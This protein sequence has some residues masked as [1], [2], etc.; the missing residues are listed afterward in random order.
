MNYLNPIGIIPE[1]LT[2][3]ECDLIIGT[4]ERL[5]WD[6]GMIGGA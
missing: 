6:P 3:Q 4:A 5:A 2:P 1:F